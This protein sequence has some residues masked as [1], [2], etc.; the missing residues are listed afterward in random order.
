MIDEK[1]ILAVIPA[2]GGSKGVPRKNIRMLAGK[3]LIAW[4]IAEALQSK[5]IDRLILSSEDEE[6]IEVAKQY[7]CEV[8]F[9]RP[10][11][12][13]ADD[14]PGIE[15]ILHAVQALSKPYDYV[16]VL[17]PTSPLRTVGDIDGC[18]KHCFS[19]EA[20]CCVSICEA[21][22]SP[23]WMFQL[24]ETSTMSPLIR[25]NRQYM[26]RQ[27]LP[28]TYLLNGALYLADVKQLIQTRS[29]VTDNTIGYIMPAERSVDIDNERDFQLCAEQLMASLGFQYL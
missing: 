19:H 9:Q 4:T 12:F 17:Q 8:P 26:R 28:K 29:F 14:T 11:E 6:I 16:L 10:K 15:P 27:D 24:N 2:R 21:K 25:S 18:I 5:Y 22:E 1:S 20:S 23:Y 7:G 3:P 13:A